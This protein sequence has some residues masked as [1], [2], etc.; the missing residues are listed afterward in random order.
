MLSEQRSGV[1]P[2]NR[3]SRHNTGGQGSG[4]FGHKSHCAGSAI[5]FML[6]CTHDFASDKCEEVGVVLPRALF[7]GSR[8][9]LAGQR[10]ERTQAG[11]GPGQCGRPWFGKWGGVKWSLVLPTMNWNS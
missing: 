5:P 11:K 9:E 3:Q 8:G 10:Q 4:F 2:Q 1:V 6:C 7:E